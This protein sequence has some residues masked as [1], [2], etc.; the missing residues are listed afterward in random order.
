MLPPRRPGRRRGW[1]LAAAATFIVEVFAMGPRFWSSG[2]IADPSVTSDPMTSAAA[3][4]TAP[5]TPAPVTPSPSTTPASEPSWTSNLL[6]QLE[7]D[8]PPASI[9]GEVGEVYAEGF[10]PESPE[11][12]MEAFLA[13]TEFTSL[14]VRGYQR[15]DVEGHWARFVHRVDGTIK[16]VV[17]LRDAGPVVDPGVW[18]VAG[19]RACDP[20]EFAPDSGSTGALLTVWL[21]AE[22][23][24]VPTTIVH[25]TQGPGHCGWESTIWL[26]LD[27][28]LFLRDSK[29]V[30]EQAVVGDFDPDVTL[31]TDARSTGYHEGGRTIWRDGDPDAIYVVM[32]DRVERWPR[33][34]D[35]SMGCA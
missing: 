23:A 14:P 13:I 25:E 22:G 11:V 21:D 10:S 26:R 31:P 4:S 35:P 12:A 3:A 2:A 15:T 1:L 6:G 30:L 34:L 28:A 17:V 9:G 5:A 33:A 16:A 20:A 29:G 24:R 7:C 27:G 8:G 18:S 32:V 19:L